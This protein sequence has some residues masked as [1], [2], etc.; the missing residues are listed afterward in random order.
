MDPQLAGIYVT[1]VEMDEP[2]PYGF[3]ECRCGEHTNISAKTGLPSR[4]RRGHH[5]RRHPHGWTVEDRGFTSPCWIWNG[6]KDSRGYAEGKRKKDGGSVKEHRTQWEKRHGCSIPEGGQIHHLCEQTSCVNPDH[7]ELVPTFQEHR[8]RHAKKLSLEKAREIRAAL[9]EGESGASLARRYGVSSAEIT[10]IRQGVHWFEDGVEPI[11]VKPLTLWAK[12]AAQPTPPTRGTSVEYVVEDRGH[13][14]PC[15][16]AAKKPE[17]NGYVV[18]PWHEYDEEA[19]WHG[20]RI[21][22]HR[23]MYM[24]S[25]GPIP[26][27]LHLHHRCHI[28]NCINPDHLE[29]VTHTE[30]NRQSAATKLDESK[31]RS[32]R[33][34]SERNAILAER[35]GVSPD[36]IYAVRTGRIW[37]D[38]H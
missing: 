9:R 29:P 15:W 11:P 37:K 23:L 13:E 32:I 2:V 17:Q 7:L 6:A 12:F 33:A 21:G 31:V 5:S 38:V 3:C 14:T 8:R 34:S 18:V 1:M 22:A 36:T 28:R 30:N 10:F 24:R 16:I 20:T 35:F 4:F 19:R 26:S 27:G 25:K